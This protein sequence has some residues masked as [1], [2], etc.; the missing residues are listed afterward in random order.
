MEPNPAN[1]MPPAPANSETPFVKPNDTTLPPNPAN[2]V[3][4]STNDEFDN[5][6]LHAQPI[7]KSFLAKHS[8]AILLSGL[9]LSIILIA[10]GIFMRLTYDAKDDQ[11]R[12]VTA[13]Q[14]EIET[15]ESEV[16]NLTANDH[17][18]FQ[19]SGFSSSFYQSSN[20]RTDAELRK[21]DL[22]HTL[23]TLSAANASANIFNTGAVYLF[24]AG[25]ICLF[26][27]ITIF[28]A[29]RRQPKSSSIVAK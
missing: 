28:L 16:S 10:V 9:G 12:N 14:Q 25:M 19:N 8:M 24:L 23:D 3:A 5:A 22:Q 2:L 7:K 27:T 6:F 17:S 11:G 1:P 18:V 13:L 26:V 15:L 4:P 20:N 21:A 29:S